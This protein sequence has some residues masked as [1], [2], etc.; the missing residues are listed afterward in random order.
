[1]RIAYPLFLA[2]S[3]FFLLISQNAQADLR[4]VQEKYSGMVIN[5][6]VF[7]KSTINKIYNGLARKHPFE[8]FDK[9]MLS[10]NAIKE[11]KQN[12]KSRIGKFNYT[13]EMKSGRVEVQSRGNNVKRY[14]LTADLSRDISIIANAVIN[15][16]NISKKETKRLLEFIT[17]ALVT[18]FNEFSP[19]GMKYYKMSSGIIRVERAIR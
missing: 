18:R 17:D 5:G 19:N 6:K 15:E 12:C 11:V 2:S 14:R 7:D 8:I 9:I 13:C 16:V 3:L 4:K 1:M 10:Q